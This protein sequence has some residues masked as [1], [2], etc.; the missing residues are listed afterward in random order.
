MGSVSFEDIA[1]DFSWDEWQHL[2]VAQRTLYRDVMLENYSS[3]L[4]LGHCMTKP[5]VIFQL[6]HGFGPWPVGDS[7]VRSF[8]GIHKV[9]TSFDT[10][11][12]NHKGYLWQVEITNSQ[13][14]NEKITEADLKV[15]QKIQQGTASYED[16]DV[17]KAFIQQ[18][19]HTRSEMSY[20]CKKSIQCKSPLSNCQ[21]LL[22]EETRHT[23]RQRRKSHL[24]EQRSHEGE[25]PCE[26][27]GRGKASHTKPQR[28]AN[29]SDEK[30][31]K[32]LECG[33]YFYYKSQVIEHQ[34]S[35][36]GEKPYE[37]TECGKSFSYKSHLTIHHRSHTGATARAS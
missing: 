3:L 36:T 5:E 35:H 20:S 24:T 37:C 26:S 10:H 9:T 32:C 14:S 12:E 21:R 2:D 22:S 28:Q 4:F 31:Y 1:V 34:R 17:V 7:S 8:A 29:H 6:E 23:H 30:P 15:A 19:Q 16:K 27:S 11:Q 33:K 13:T 25:K 18:S